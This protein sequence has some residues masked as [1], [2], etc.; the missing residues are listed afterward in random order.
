MA[1]LGDLA[2]A[3]IRLA[4][5]GGMRALT[6][7]AVDAEAGLPPGSTSYY[8][9]TRRDLT[10]LVARRVTE[11]LATDLAAVNLPDDLDDV[12]VVQIATGF[13]EDLAQRADAQA[14]RLALLL[15]LRDDHDL[16]LPLT[17]ADPVRAQLVETARVLLSALGI[18]EPD[19]AA[20]DFVGLIDALLLYRTADVAP[21]DA[22]RVLT[23]YVAGLDRA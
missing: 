6:H 23:A 12:A 10:V 1:R 13:L 20:I 3:G 14:A 18:V 7:R 9:R 19:R 22:H 11:Q 21:L 4:A 17:G 16:R 15:E 8:A 5:R 2:D